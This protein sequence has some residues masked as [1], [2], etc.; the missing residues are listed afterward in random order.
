MANL[1]LKT[2]YEI[3]QHAILL[4]CN[5]LLLLLCLEFVDCGL[6]VICGVICGLI[7]ICGV[8]C[9]LIVICGVGNV[10]LYDV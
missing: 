10:L 5:V 6:V 7:V 4:F 8:V 9:G 3:S 1:H 2:C